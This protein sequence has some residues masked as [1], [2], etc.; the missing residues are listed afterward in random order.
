MNLVVALTPISSLTIDTSPFIY[1]I[2]KNPAYITRS[3]EVFRLIDQGKLLGLTS[4]L[5]LTEVLT[6]PIKMNN[7]QLQK[8]YRNVFLGSKGVELVPVGYAIAER[9]A[10]LRARYNLRTP[11][12]IH[13]ATALYTKCN[14]FLTNDVT[15]KRVTEIPVLILDELTL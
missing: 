3:R 15:F 12:A 6:Q 5:T 9:A 13:I 14:A 10:D 1:F 11:D 4:I 7:A 8:T 2:E